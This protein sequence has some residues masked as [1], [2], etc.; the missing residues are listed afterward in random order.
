MK[1]LFKHFIAME[2]L[3]SFYRHNTFFKHCPAIKIFN[4]NNNSDIISDFIVSFN[5]CLSI[6]NHI[7]IT[8]LFIFRSMIRNSLIL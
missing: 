6:A 8:Y 3:Y 7:H 4:N 1:T 2:P 5:N